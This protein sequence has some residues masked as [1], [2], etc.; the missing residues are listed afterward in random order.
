[1][2]DLGPGGGD[3]KEDSPWTYP[4]IIIVLT[5]ILSGAVAY[6]YFGPSISDLRGD[7]PEASTRETPIHMRIGTTDYVIPENY[8]QLPRDR[9]GGARDS[10]ALYAVFPTFE[11]YS[12]RN[13][14]YFIENESDNPIIYFEI[15]L[16]RLPMTEAQRIE[17]IYRENLAEG[18]GEE[19]GF[20][21]TQYAFAGDSSYA[22]EELFLGETAD[23]QVVAILCTK[24]SN[25]VPSPNCRRDVELP[26]GLLLSYRFKRA[27]LDQWLEITNGVGN[28]VGSFR[29]S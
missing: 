22:D 15:H 13:D 28:L 19:L 25:M 20:G 5:I 6:Y 16:A 9:R 11:P 27:H 4:L 23:G 21:L 29:A 17:M 2:S 24:L 14:R 1:M 26:D 10:V 8:T 18:Q 7:T 12:V 3:I